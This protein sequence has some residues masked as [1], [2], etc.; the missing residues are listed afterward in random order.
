MRKLQFRLRFA[1]LAVV[2]LMLPM[3]ACNDHDDPDNGEGVARVIGTTYT[4]TS[5]MAMPPEAV[6]AAVEVMIEDRSGSSSGFFNAVTFTS[7]T[8]DYG[9][10]VFPP[11]TN[12]VISTAYIS[13][14]STGTIFFTVLSDAQK[15]MFPAGGG[16]SALIH[17]DGQDLLGNPVS[18]DAIL[19]VIIEP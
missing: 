7:F 10:V 15:Q 16:V 12:G 13:V 1:A 14:G 8:L 6:V 11:I 17:V 4:G 2:V 3:V 18:F 9:G 19:V 5:L